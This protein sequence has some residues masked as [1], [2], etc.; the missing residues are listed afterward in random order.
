MSEAPQHRRQTGRFLLEL[1]VVAVVAAF[2]VTRAAKRAEEP[3][4]LSQESSS[5]SAPLAAPEKASLKPAVPPRAIAIAAEESGPPPAKTGQEILPEVEIVPAGEKTPPKMRLKGVKRPGTAYFRKNLPPE[6]K[7]PPRD[8]RNAEA[9]SA[10]DPASEAAR[11]RE[12][13]PVILDRPDIDPRSAALARERP[14]RDEE[15]G[16]ISL[17][18]IVLCVGGVFAVLF[19][20]LVRA[21]SRGPG[22]KG[23]SFD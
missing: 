12:L 6:K 3:A 11:E 14:A 2:V 8:P 23:L 21:L 17:R 18:T 19:F 15:A 16:G 10:A 1:V 5:V 9:G 20:F 13:T 4:A 22:G 7:G